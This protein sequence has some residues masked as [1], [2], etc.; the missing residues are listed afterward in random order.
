MKVSSPLFNSPIGPLHD[1]VTWYGINYAEPKR[2][3]SG[4]FET[5]ESLAE[6]VRVPLSW[7]FHCVTCAKSLISWLVA[8]SILVAAC[9]PSCTS[10]KLVLKKPGALS[11]QP[12]FPD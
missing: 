4:A 10:Y 9:E 11:I 7:K 2:L 8:T 12:K 6:L 1:P 5:K 3:Y